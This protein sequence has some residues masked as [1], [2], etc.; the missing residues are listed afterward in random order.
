[1]THQ[2][3]DAVFISDLHLHPHNSDITQ[4]FDNFIQW[5]AKST[6][7]LYILG[8]FFHVWSGDDS[9]NEW[10]K[11][12]AAQLAYLATQNIPIYF[13][14]GNRDFLVGK[15]FAEQAQITLLPDPYCFKLGEHTVLLAH[16]DKYC[17]NDKAHQRFR[18]ITRHP[19][20]QYLFLKLPL[21]WRNFLVARV[22]KVSA[23]KNLPAEHQ[24]FRLSEAILDKEMQHFRADILIHGHT[25]Q[26]SITTHHTDALIYQHYILSDWDDI[27]T[28]LCYD[29]SIGFYFDHFGDAKSCQK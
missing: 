7:A 23:Q 19:L 14:A 8:D 21:K 1:M 22:R 28:V 20:F 16:G 17:A 26:P 10:S 3:L 4:R 15:Y 11:R 2:P 5:A 6:K 24:K 9:L 18:A 27:P 12:I 25:H 13:L 29:K